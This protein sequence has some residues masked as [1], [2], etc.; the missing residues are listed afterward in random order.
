MT[1]SKPCSK[2]GVILPLDSFSINKKGK[3]GRS[4]V[5]KPCSK[6]HYYD[7]DKATAKVRAFRATEKGITKEREWR[8]NRRRNFPLVRIVQEAK[9]RAK[10]NGIPFDLDHDDLTIPKLCPVLGIPIGMSYGHRSDNSLSL[11]R[12]NNKKGYVKGNVIIIS[13]RA[14]RLKS[15]ATIDEIAKIYRFYRKRK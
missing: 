7:K 14:N 10:K 4:S 13:W 2:C 12:V 8:N 1:I 15:D 6:K 11:E 9:V 5:C 3:H